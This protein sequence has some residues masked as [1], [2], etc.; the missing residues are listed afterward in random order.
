MPATSGPA[1]NARALQ[2][3]LGGAWRTDRTAE[4]APEEDENWLASMPLLRDW[5]S[6]REPEDGRD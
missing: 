5:T 6:S 3:R 1:V 4:Q 2:E